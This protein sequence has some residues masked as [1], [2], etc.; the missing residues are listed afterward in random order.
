MN[1]AIVIINI[2]RHAEMI[3]CLR[4]LA[5]S[6]AADHAR[7]YSCN[8][9]VSPAHVQQ[10]QRLYPD[11]EQIELDQ[12]YGYAGNNNIGIERAMAD[13]ADWI[14]LLN[15][16]TEFAPDCFSA[17]VRVAMSD[18]T[19]GIV[20]P[21]V[22]H[23][24]EP[25]VIQSAGADLGPLWR[26]EH[27]GQNEVDRG[28][29]AGPRDVDWVS[30]CALLVHRDV[31]Q[32]VGPLDERF[33]MYWEETEWCLRAKR[34]G[35]R[36]VQ[37]PEARLWHKGVRRDYRPAPYVTYYMTRNRFLFLQKHRAP[38]AAWRDV[39]MTTLRTLAAFTLKDEWRDIKAEERTMLRRALRDY[40]VNRWGPM[41]EY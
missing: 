27:A 35:F 14:L 29:F 24:D 15:D 31:V 16:D 10:L 38:G 6:E 34:G 21:M 37:V 17:L 12:N 32:R 33:F 4:S 41:P 8:L 23:F 40:W 7:V 22:Y 18:P 39:W 3:A 28:Q 26:S 25:N 19:I 20:G 30:G 1:L 11:I 2:D 5:R 13:G 9:D 36:V